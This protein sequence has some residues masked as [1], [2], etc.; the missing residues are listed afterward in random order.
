MRSINYWHFSIS[1]DSA[2]SLS[3][4]PAFSFVRSANSFVRPTLS[5]SSS[6]LNA[7]L[8]SLASR[9]TFRIFSSNV[10][11]SSKVVFDE[12]VDSASSIF[13]LVTTTVVVLSISSPRVRLTSNDQL[14]SSINSE[15]KLLVGTTAKT[16]SSSGDSEIWTPG[17]TCRWELSMDGC[18]E[19]E[20]AFTFCYN[21]LVSRPR[22][23]I[24]RG[25]GDLWRH[26]INWNNRVSLP[27][28]LKGTDFSICR[29]VL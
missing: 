15:I 21:V 22:F 13:I 1:A 5:A 18:R 4:A 23:R 14:C 7:L 9:L 11:I 25:G 17:A 12:L 26:S 16:L 10:L 2:F 6:A 8:A 27:D 24:T 20:P 3:S 19:D 29:L 28:R